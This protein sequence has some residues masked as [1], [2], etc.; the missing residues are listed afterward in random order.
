MLINK[1]YLGLGIMLLSIFPIENLDYKMV[2]NP[3][4]T[5]TKKVS[6][7][8]KN[9]QDSGKEIYTDFCIQCHMA[10]GKGDGLNFPPL[11]GS[12]WLTKKRKE[13]IYSVKFGQTG[14]IVVNN[15][16]FNNTMPSMGLSNKE[17]ADVMNYIMNSWSNKQKKKVTEKE[18]ESVLK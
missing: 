5:K 18:V 7:V 4:Y 2:N 13:S 10:N 6:V 16:K 11:D 1:L 9:L 3:I 14:E 12:N 17:V 8:E 15:K